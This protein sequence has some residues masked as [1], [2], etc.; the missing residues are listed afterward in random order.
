MKQVNKRYDKGQNIM[1][2]GSHFF[3][4][5]YGYMSALIVSCALFCLSC[6][7]APKEE[8]SAETQPEN[9]IPLFNGENLDGWEVKISGYPAGENFGNTFRVEDGILKVSYD[10]YN[11]DFQDRFG[12]IYTE[13][14]YSQYKLRVEYRFSGEQIKGGPEWAYLNN[15]VMLHAQD[16][17]TMELNQSFPVS[18]EAQLLGSDDKAQRSTGNVCSPGTNVWINNELYPD[19]CASS[20]SRIYPANEWVTM[21]IVVY[22]DSLVHHIIEGDTIMTYTHLTI[23]EQ[24]PTTKGL[25]PGALKSGRIALQSESAPTEFRKIELLDLSAKY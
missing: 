9:W 17:K 6:K 18:V 22:G 19:H 23:D 1:S 7:Q 3:S 8:T 2:V 11:D 4:L 20:S 12:H 13:K 10:A 25:T 24:D 15:G 21:E 16:P 14:E 5:K